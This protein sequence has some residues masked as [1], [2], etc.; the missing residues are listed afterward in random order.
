[1]ARNLGEAFVQISPDL[2]GFGPELQSGVESAMAKAVA[3]VEEANS[4]IAQSFSET[5]QKA[6]TALGQVDGDGFQKV[7][8]SADQAGDQVVSDLRASAKQADDALSEVDGDKFQEARDEAKKAGKAIGDSLEDGA[9]Q[10]DKALRNLAKSAG[11]A[12]LTAG[13]TKF[14]KASVDA[15]ADLGETVSKATVIFGDSVDQIIAYGDN[16]SQALGQSKQA[17]IAAAS[18]FAIFGTAAGLTGSELATFSTNLTSLASDLASFSNTTPEDAVLAL[19]AALRGESEPIRRYGVLLNDASLKARALEIGIYDGNGAL[20]SQQKVLAANAEIFAQ[21]T[22]AQGDFER[23]SSSLAN[24][25]KILAAEFKDLQVTIG[26]ALA[27]AFGQLVSIAGGALDAF[28]ALPSSVQSFIAV[29]AIGVAG[30]AAMSNAIQN[31]GV[32]A[33]TANLYLAG[34]TAAVV[35]VSLLYNALTAEAKRAEERQKALNDALIEAN[36][37]AA[38]LATRVKEL[39]TEYQ[40]MNPATEEA[41]EGVD[42]LAGALGFTQTQLGPLTNALLKTGL[43]VLDITKAVEG[44]T[45]AFQELEGDLKQVLFGGVEL[46]DVLDRVQAT[47]D[48]T[49]GASHPLAASLKEVAASGTLTSQE[50]LKLIDGLDETAD[51]FDD[52][53]EANEKSNKALFD[54]EKVVTGFAQILGEDLYNSLLATSLATAEAEGNSFGYTYALEQI[55][56]EILRVTES[57]RA[58]WEEM[59][60]AARAAEDA[61]RAQASYDEELKIAEERLDNAKEALDGVIDSQ[62]AL[63]DATLGAINS[64]INYQ[65]QIDRT[66]KALQ[67]YQTTEDDLS[68]TINEKDA[69]LRDA[70][71]Q[72]LR[73]SE[74]AVQ[75]AIDNGTLTEAQL[76]AGGAQRLMA[77][78]LRTVAELLSPNDPLR[79]NLLGYAEQLENH[80]PDTVET[81]IIA[82]VEGAKEDL[83]DLTG[84]ATAAGLDTGRNFANGVAEGIR[85]QTAGIQGQ[86]ETLIE[87]TR[88]AARRAAEIRSP[89]Q[90]F[91]REVGEPIADGIAEGIERGE[92]VVIQ[93]MDDLS[94]SVLDIASETVY[95]LDEILAD[96]VRSAESAFDGVLDLIQGR[97]NQEAAARRV[98]DAEERVADAQENVAK[99]LEEA[100]AGSK[101]YERALRRLEDA[102]I[103]LEEA[104]FRYLET[105]YDLIEQGPEGIATFENLARAAGLELDEIE[106]LVEAYQELLQARK[107]QDDYGK[108]KE[109]PGQATG[110]TGTAPVGG[111]IPGTNIPIVIGTEDRGQPYPGQ[112]VGGPDRLWGGTGGGAVVDGYY[113]PPGVDFGSLKGL[114]NGA[115]V[116][117]AT[118]A[119]IGEA[120]PEVV[121]PIS[122]PGRALDLMAESG[123]LDLAQG[124]LPGQT[125]PTVQIQNATFASATD[126]DLVA[127]KVN[128]AYLSRTVIV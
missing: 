110:G 52:Q 119:I 67:D 34:I 75:A 71:T 16:A 70:T 74:A 31:L 50:F 88:F 83:R 115:I 93:S 1:M 33:K 98:R 51:A 57:E 54:N 80:I 106:K 76:A 12:A 8:Q 102:Q 42:G 35:G 59:D 79:A 124:A 64:D 11:F 48:D 100:G 89:S 107:D 53:R 85:R 81:E 13:I 95:D 117:Q 39:V 78:E 127:Q 126:A 58:R 28:S 44:G 91:A 23:T 46:S 97:R 122:R 128:A 84:A 125:G 20:T 114:A 108:S 9:E 4:E 15:F 32:T 111:N 17:A 6:E 63:I 92:Y 47:I 72:I 66:I 30:F 55:E 101:E 105:Q 49:L 82:E 65:N 61:E 40:R 94:V 90:L 25:Q 22:L 24:Q 96:L 103:G 38:T 36:D 99:A 37:P 56:A 10:G 104:N 18:D 14:A 112:F 19:G 120:G 29:G 86:V 5:A 3:E 7:R 2:S 87:E 68:T 45:D 73:Q 21:T 26:Q 62:Y 60:L 43:S 118:A 109:Q 69:A 121:I 113:I 27:P 77:D 116:D 123:L 41:E